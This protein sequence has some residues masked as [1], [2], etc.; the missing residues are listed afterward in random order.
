MVRVCSSSLALAACITL[1]PT[2]LAAPVDLTVASI[3]VTQGFQNG[4]T[5]LVGGRATM[6]R[7]KI[8]VSGS[9]GAVAGVD[10]V[11]RMFVDGVESSQ[12]PFYSQNGPISAPLSPN[13]AN[14]DDTLNFIVV[15]PESGIVSFRV[16]VNPT[17]SISESTYANNLFVSPSVVFACRAIVDLAYV[18]IDYTPSG[19]PPA[20]EM[21]EPGRADSFL[22]GIFAVREWNYHRSPL[23][24]LTWS[25]GINSSGTQMLNTLLD[26]RNTQIPGAGYQ[27]PEFVYGFLPGNPYNGNGLAIGIPG[28]VAF[29]NTQE[30]RWQRTF[31]HEVGHLWGQSHNSQQISMPSIDVEHQLKDPLGIGVLQPSSKSD[32]MVAGLQTAQAWVASSTYNKCI[33]DGR[34]QCIS[35]DDPD[36]GGD[37]GADAAQASVPCLRVA[38]VLTH[39]GRSVEL[40]P[41]F[42]FEEVTPTQDDPAGDVAVE[43]LDAAG[44]LLQRVRLRTDTM[45]ESCCGRGELIPTSSIYALL[46][47]RA[48]ARIDRVVIRDLTAGAGAR[49]MAQRD[50]SPNAPTAEIISAWP[51]VAAPAPAGNAWKANPVEVQWRSSDA[52]GDQV[53]SMLLYSPDGGRR[54]APVTVNPSGEQVI[55]DPS[56]LPGAVAGQGRLRLLVTDGFQTTVVDGTIESMYMQ[57]QPPD[58][59]IISPNADTYRRGASVVLHASGWDMED[60][61]LPDDAFD[62]TSDLDGSV[63]NGRLLTTRHLSPGS[64]VLTLA[65]SDSDGLSTLRTVPVTISARSI[66]TADIDQNGTVDGADLAMM[67]GNWGNFGVGDLSFDGVVDGNDLAILLG[68]WAP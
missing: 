40:A 21:M 45:R 12:G 64:H 31:A 58:V 30:N 22:R 59:H 53:S 24:A 32:V 68:A 42:R 36:G 38:G 34:S 18:S 26:I 41:F 65:G 11:L 43:A 54:W 39:D 37:G 25:S 27:K 62:W 60:Q 4:S 14:L 46:P 66:P 44:R 6:V 20:P 10:A 57:G 51:A 16:L 47:I 49:V 48:D 63:G 61:Y 67:L 1:A 2:A 3:E 35:S 13:S 23:G 29:G 28:A 55:F 19:G 15:P 7:V 52:D 9:G 17:A 50:R 33:T 8:G 56:G 5:T